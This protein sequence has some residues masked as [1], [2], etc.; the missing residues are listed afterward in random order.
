MRLPRVFHPFSLRA[1]TRRCYFQSEPMT[2]RKSVE[3]V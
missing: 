1:Q 2:T 3:N